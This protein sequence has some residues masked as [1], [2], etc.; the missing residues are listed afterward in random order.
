MGYYFSEAVILKQFLESLDECHIRPKYREDWVMD[1][2]LRR[3]A[4]EGDSS[5]QTAGAY[6]IHAD[7]YPNW[8]V[9]DYHH[10]S[11]MQ[12]FKLDLSTLTPDELADY[13]AQL[14]KRESSYSPQTYEERE[15]ARQFFEV[16]NREKKAQSEALKEQFRQQQ[17]RRAC[18]EYNMAGFA[19]ALYHPYMCERFYSVPVPEA[20]KNKAMSIWTRDFNLWEHNYNIDSKRPSTDNPHTL[21]V[22]VGEPVKGGPCR[23]GDLLIPLTDA[24]TGKF[25]TLQI[26][27]RE[28]GADGKYPKRWYAGLPI[29]NVCYK[30]AVP[31]WI[32]EVN[33]TRYG[34]PGCEHAQT[35]LICEGFCTGLAVL[36]M[37]QG[38]YPVFCAMTS[39]NLSNVA[40]SLRQRFP[41]MKIILMADNDRHTELK[42]GRNPG[43]EAAKKLK[44]AGLIDASKI[45]QIP[46][47]ENDNIDY[48]DVLVA[49]TKSKTYGLTGGKNEH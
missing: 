41:N 8:G 35:I 34:L 11:E 17:Y 28:K 6:F 3:F 22:V 33:G 1:G 7:D 12:L 45:P 47:R 49:R 44:Q 10:H 38:A 36:T 43:V 30:F 24:F 15:H 13:H 40:R 4:V 27:S 19:S 39:V 42:T 9:M 32:F 37:T 14:P 48:Y 5:G 26:I 31:E 23:E 29:D 2:L 20:G 25:R 21:G 16:K 46:G 18:E